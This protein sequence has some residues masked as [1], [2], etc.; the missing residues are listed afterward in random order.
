MTTE[1]Q[2]R[3]AMRA[4]AERVEIEPRAWTAVQA[5]VRRHRARRTIGA[6]VLTAAAL[7]AA[8]VGVGSLLADG[9][10]RRVHTVG[11]GPSAGSTTTV[12]PAETEGTFPG[13]WPFTSQRAVDDYLADSGVGMF[14]DGEATAL[15]FAREYLGM[16][17]PVTTHGFVVL[18]DATGEVEVLPRR[19]TPMT[20]TIK[21]H[22]FGGAHGAYSVVDVN[23]DNIEVDRP[24]SGQQVGTTIVLTGRSTAF[25][26]NVTVE[27][28]QDGQLPG[29]HLGRSFVMGGANGEMGPFAGDITIAPPTAA[30]GAVILATESAEDGIVQEAT[31]R[32]VRFAERQDAA[33]LLRFSVFF[34]RDEELVE[35][36]RESG[37]TVGVLRAAMEALFRGPMPDEDGGRLSSPFSAATADLLAGVNLRPDGTAVVDLA[38][39]VPN[40]S[41]STGSARLL[42]E[43]DATAFQFSTVE[44]IEYRLHGDCDAFWAWLQYGDCRLVERPAR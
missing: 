11:P 39:T 10:D 20:T 13:I 1:E 36:G 42:E 26:A 23:A 41:S 6:S 31:V 33:G 32:R 18:D 43:L 44:R 16:P 5:R 2:L 29:E 4:E 37:R 28:R 34:H 22:R 19:R 24:E 30:A 38:D 17:D 8:V 12:P 21:V 25:E 9:D 35:V 15:E 27:V 7:V 14:L 40:A 3:R